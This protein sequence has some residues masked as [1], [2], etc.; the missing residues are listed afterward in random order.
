MQTSGFKQPPASV[1][2]VYRPAEIEIVEKKSRFIASVLPIR[3]E[4]EALAFLEG[5]RKKHYNASHNCYAYQIGERHELSRFSDDGEPGG[6]AGM[7]MLNVLQAEDVHDV[8]VVVT[9]YFGGTLLGAGGLVR[10]YTKATHDGLHAAQV[11]TKKLYARML[12]DTDYN[13]SGKVQYGT[14]NAGHIIHDT[15]YT[16]IV[17]FTVL[18]EYAAV[19]GFVTY[20]QDLTAATAVVTPDD[21]VYGADVDGETVLFPVSSPCV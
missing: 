4:P 16:D 12:V 15:V 21:F 8:I 10:A 2:T 7:P 17:R 14:L 3:T 20:I 9:R 1:V 5:L 13:L 19:D 6:T 18:V 11:I